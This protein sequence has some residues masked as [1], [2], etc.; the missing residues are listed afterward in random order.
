MNLLIH[1]NNSY[2][3]GIINWY[4]NE[5]KSE[6]CRF[7]LSENNIVKINNYQAYK[8]RLTYCVAD[9]KEYC[10]SMKKE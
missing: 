2:Y 3:T 4:V 9:R 8:G 5:K 10:R 1:V 6:I 7:V